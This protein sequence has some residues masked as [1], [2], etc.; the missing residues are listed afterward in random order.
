MKTI[1]CDKPG[2]SSEMK[3]IASIIIKGIKKVEIAVFL[4]MLFFFSC[5][6]KVKAQSN[7]NIPPHCAPKLC[8]MVVIDFLFSIL[9]GNNPAIVRNNPDSMNK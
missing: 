4:Q 1:R 7:Q 2:V 6:H 5:H 8:I 9:A 3:P